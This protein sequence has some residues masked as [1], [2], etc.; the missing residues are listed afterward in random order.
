MVIW[1]IIRCSAQVPGAKGERVGPIMPQGDG[2][3]GV[4]FTIAS[5]V[6]T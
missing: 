5:A 1:S 3:L 2:G 4:V 6:G